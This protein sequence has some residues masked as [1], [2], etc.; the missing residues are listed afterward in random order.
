MERAKVEKELAWPLPY[1]TLPYLTL[2]YLTLPYL[3]LPYLTLP[4]LTLPYLTLPYLTLPYL[5]L[6]YL[7]F[8]SPQTTRIAT[9][10]NLLLRWLRVHPPAPQ[11][12]FPPGLSRVKPP[13]R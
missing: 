1:L 4:Y 5:T 11:M 10:D 12:Q 2:P 7:T 3:T 13:P 8:P 6:P 9:A